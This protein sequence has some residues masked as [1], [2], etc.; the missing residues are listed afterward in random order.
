MK[1]EERAHLRHILQGRREAIVAHWYNALAPAGATEYSAADFRRQLGALTDQAIT[2]LLGE[3]FGRQGARDIGAALARLD[4]HPAILGRTLEALAA[5]LVAGLT[6]KQVVALHPRLMA[7]LGELA[8]GFGDRAG[9]ALFVERRRAKEAL[10]ES[11][12]RLRVVVNHVPIILFAIDR[13]GIFTLAEGQGLAV[14]RLQSGEAVGRAVF[15]LCRDFP[16]VLKNVRRALAGETFTATVEVGETVFET[17]YSPTHEPGGNASGVI[18]V[19]ADITARV[20]AET[21]SRASEA[22]FRALLHEVPLGTRSPTG[23]A[24]CSAV[25]PSTRGWSAIARPNC[26]AGA[27]PWS[28]T[29]TTRRATWRSSGSCWRGAATA[30]TWRSATAARTG[31]LSGAT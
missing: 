1:V 22:R 3:P 28:R 14:L 20:R 27:S 18:G 26:A 23:N 8:T 25:M 10:T 19:A 7:L 5:Q 29:R 24:N 16:Q 2:V 11:E 15:D 17:W 30:M 9:G 31:G 21:A 13:Q 12:R 4:A 6:A